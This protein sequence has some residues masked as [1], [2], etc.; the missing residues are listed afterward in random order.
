MRQAN[1]GGNR[2]SERYENAIALLVA[3]KASL[4]F[5]RRVGLFNLS[6]C[7]VVSMHFSAI[8]FVVVY[9]FQQFFIYFVVPMLLTWVL[10]AA[11]LQLFFAIVVVVVIIC[12]A[13][14]A[15]GNANSL[16]SANSLFDDCVCGFSRAS[17]VIVVVDFSCKQ[18]VCK[19]RK[20]PLRF[21]YENNQK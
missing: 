13:N 11:R 19:R 16:L 6:D 7:C 15:V 3:T 14:T 12:L 8:I 21:Y 17:Y 4:T 1:S 5:F 20:S 2:G 18:S 9:F 10:L